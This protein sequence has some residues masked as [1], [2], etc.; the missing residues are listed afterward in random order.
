MTLKVISALVLTTIFW[1][2]FIFV[3]FQV[4]YPESLTSANTTQLISFFVPLYLSL[5]FTLNIFLK[6][7][8]ISA[9]LSLG[10]IFLLILKALDSLNFVTGILLIISVYLL[11]SYFK[12]GGSSGLTLSSKIPKLHSLRR[13]RQ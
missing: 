10:L 6:N 3:I 12:K 1:L 2:G 13:K 8:S 7:I 5:I 11:V 9:S 4:P